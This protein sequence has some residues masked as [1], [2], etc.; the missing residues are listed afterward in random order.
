MSSSESGQD[1]ILLYNE[2]LSAAFCAIMGLIFLVTGLFQAFRAVFIRVKRKKI[3]QHTTKFMLAFAVLS[4]LVRSLFFAVWQ[5][6][7]GV[8]LY[9]FLWWLPHCL[10]LAVCVLFIR[11]WA[12]TFATSLHVGE[13][14]VLR[15][16]KTWLNLA[17]Y[18]LIG[19]IALSQLSVW[20]VIVGVSDEHFSLVHDISLGVSIACE[21]VPLF[22]T[23]VILLVVLVKHRK[24]KREDMATSP[25][26]PGGILS[27][28][29]RVEMVLSFWMLARLVRIADMI[30]MLMTTQE[31]NKLINSSLYWMYIGPYYL[32]SELVPGAMIVFSRVVE[33]LDYGMVNYRKME[34]SY[35]LGIRSNSNTGS[36][37]KSTGSGSG[38]Y[39]DGS[40]H[41]K[42]WQDEELGEASSLLNSVSADPMVSHWTIDYKKLAL[43]EYVGSGAGGDVWKAVYQDSVVAVK[44]LKRGLMDSPRDLADFCSEMKMLSSL[45]HDNIVSFYGACLVP[46]NICIVSEYMQRKSLRTV[47]EDTRLELPFSLRMSMMIDLCKGLHYVHSNRILHRDLKP[48]NLMIGAHFNLKI[49][50]FGSGRVTPHA[51]NTTKT[52]FAQS[53]AGS[54]MYIAPEVFHRKYTYPADVYSMGIVFWEVISRTQISRCG[55]S[56]DEMH[57]EGLRPDIPDSCPAYFRGLIVQCWDLDAK[58]RP[59]VGQVLKAL[60]RW[61]QEDFRADMELLLS[62]E[63]K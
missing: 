48:E 29:S 8:D 62:Q 45:R 20:M 13:M 3:V 40:Y 54:S 22:I 50:D 37:Y 24:K 31:T 21:T 7:E 15:R 5:L 35:N 52:G 59:S 12:R 11:L 42:T 25:A 33:M 30:M 56:L 57:G 38:S 1:S 44:R 9:Y 53:I 14:F 58:Q 43:V 16:V 18:F 34:K 23:L 36:G 2:G 41:L 61:K 55:I 19:A 28:L 46:P 6:D 26:V 4:A 49:G 60:L 32:I 17:Q 39:Q 47:L 63:N 51:M 27:K 10:N